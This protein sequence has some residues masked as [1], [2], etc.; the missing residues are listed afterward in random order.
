M[1][2]KEQVRPVII[3]ALGVIGGWLRTIPWIGSSLAAMVTTEEATNFV[4]NSV[5]ALL[6][7]FGDKVPETA[8]AAMEQA[9]PIMAGMSPPQPGE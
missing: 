7:R 2:T 4:T 5:M 1:L 9:T 6:Q 8:Q 3:L